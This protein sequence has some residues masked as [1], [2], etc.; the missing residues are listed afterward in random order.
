MVEVGHLGRRSS[1][2]ST[3]ST[4]GINPAAAA[5]PTHGKCPP[6][7]LPSSTRAQAWA[8]RNVDG[9]ST[10]TSRTSDDGHDWA[11]RCH[12]CCTGS[13]ISLSGQYER[14]ALLQH[15]FWLAGMSAPDSVG[16]GTGTAGG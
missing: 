10:A 12:P 4:T 15:E 7:R 9:R 8:A 14:R 5:V 2:T 3:P 1:A 11:S 6:D 13:D 16:G